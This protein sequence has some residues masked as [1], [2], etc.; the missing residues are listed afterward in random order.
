ML[1]P[2]LRSFITLLGIF[3]FFLSLKSQVVQIKDFDVPGTYTYTVPA[4][5][6]ELVIECWGG[7]GGG[8]ASIGLLQSNAGAGAGGGGGAHAHSVIKVTPGQVYTF[9]VGTGGAGG[10]ASYTL[11]LGYGKPGGNTT[12][13]TASQSLIIAEGG[14]GASLNYWKDGGSKGGNG[15]TASGSKGEVI[16]IGGQGGDAGQEGD[17]YYS[18]GGG[19][20]GGRTH[21]GYN[22]TGQ[23]AGQ[24]GSCYCG[25]P[26][27]GGQGFRATAL[28]GGGGY[29]GNNGIDS[30]NTVRGVK[31]AA[32]GGG[33]G[34]DR[35]YGIRAGGKGAD[36]HVRIKEQ[37]A[38]GAITGTAYTEVGKTTQLRPPMAGGTWASSLIE[39]ATVDSTGL[40]T[41][42]APG[43]AVIYY[44][45]GGFNLGQSTEIHL[46]VYPEGG[47]IAIQGAL[48]Y[49]D[50]G[51][52]QIELTASGPDSV[53]WFWT[54]PDGTTL[55]GNQISRAA[56]TANSG[57]YTVTASK[58]TGD[59]LIAN[60]DFELGNTNFASDYGYNQYS[61][62]SGQYN[63]RTEPFSC[64]GFTGCPD[65]TN[66]G[67]NYMMLQGNGTSQTVWKQ[68]VSV[69]PNRNY[70]FSY[71]MQA[72]QYDQQ[73]NF[74][75]IKLQA[76]I[77]GIN[78]GGIFSKTTYK[79]C[80]GWIEFTSNWNSGSNT[81]VEISIAL[82]ENMS[83]DYMVGLDDI[84]FRVIS[85]DEFSIITASVDI[86]VGVTFTPEVTISSSPNPPLAGEPISFLANSLHGGRAPTYQWF[87][88]GIESVEDTTGIFTHTGLSAGTEIWCEL[89]PDISC[90][91]NGPFHSNSIIVISDARNYWHGTQSGNWSVIDNWTDR[92]IPGENE[93]IEF[94]TTT[95]YSSEAQRDL[96]ISSSCCIANYINQSDKKLVV[97]PGGSL[98]ITG[99]IY[100]DGENKILIQA[101]DSVKNGSLIL[102]DTTT[103]P[104]ATVEMWSKGWIGNETNLNEKYRWQFFGIP[105]QSLPASPT[106]NGS[107]VRKY[108][109]TKQT[110]EPGQQ[111][112]SLE[113]AS[114]MQPFEGY[115]ITQSVPRKYSISGMLVK[116]DFSRVL[117]VSNNSYYRGQHILANPYTAAIK[118]SEM[119]FGEGLNQ[120]VYIYNTG[121][122]ANWANA[123]GDSG[124]IVVENA[125]A[126]PGQY[127]AIPQNLSFVLGEEIP[128]MQGF[129]VKVLNP[130][131]PTQY[132]DLQR[133]LSFNY[134]DVITSNTTKQRS[135]RK[136]IENETSKTYMTI[137]MNSAN[138]TD[139][140]W[141]FVE[142]N[143]TSSFDNGWD[144]IKIEGSGLYAELT[145]LEDDKNKYQIS[146]KND[147][148]G[149]Y[150]AFNPGT[151]DTE[152]ALTFSNFNISAHYETVYLLDLETYT[153]TDI[154]DNTT[155]YFNT[156][157]YNLEKRF[158]IIT[159]PVLS[160]EDYEIKVFVENGT[161]YLHNFGSTAKD[162]IL[163]DITGRS[164]KNIK[165]IANSISLGAYA[166]PVGVYI[167]SYTSDNLTKENIK[168][169]VQ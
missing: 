148:D 151:E 164:V 96:E 29:T 108:N 51:S 120:T 81:S 79:N 61:Q 124:T 35:D 82:A 123:P 95:N 4:G 105:V 101:S 39:I 136:N 80:N 128:S 92:K 21:S 139:K 37:M 149:T 74:T 17:E 31:R 127:T 60:G 8:S 20:A 5:I 57:T 1:H 67:G 52:N 121:S 78:V 77:R 14:R 59:N 97:N 119:H 12:F 155:Y 63:I 40:V 71:K 163:Y 100:T 28:N 113:D 26:G 10:T 38:M 156:G 54:L 93:D 66:S 75:D 165:A 90:T 6:N 104:L 111:W 36:G 56:A 154:T 43:E 45:I 107:Y 106:F 145:A 135:L 150:L 109:E 141:L 166:L 99:Q 46:I 110:N 112:E 69:I 117:T 24:Q 11:A 22:A 3:F 62:Q 23:T 147:I 83:S 129:L 114:I 15:G 131:N 19:G 132:T 47:S 137:T 9:T 88:N 91:T 142:E 48:A 7:G 126:A 130:A 68:T 98:T 168:T 89:V 27:G 143:C 160:D 16:H 30:I 70:Q 18:G 65:P 2:H 55:S 94:A 116:N 161:L 33:G 140:V 159:K 86:E 58:L 85:P 115:E 157:S 50:N 125:D 49:C 53:S 118:I 44:S 167:I 158:K 13:G 138:Y 42:I 144:G 41:G 73:N 87:V 34:L 25:I 122:F 76:Q 72:M 153:V 152:Y 64:C 84:S 169:I 102:S 146:S 103:V 134:S 32:G 162:V 133:T